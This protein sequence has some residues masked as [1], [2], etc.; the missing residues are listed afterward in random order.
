MHPLKLVMRL[1]RTLTVAVSAI[2][3][4]GATLPGRAVVPQAA[5][6]VMHRVVATPKPIPVFTP[7]RLEIPKIGVDNP[8]VPVYTTT[9]GR[10]GAPTTAADVGWWAGRKAGKGNVLLDGHHDWNGVEGSFYRLA[11]LKPGDRVIVK[12]DKPDQVLTYKIIWVKNFDRNINA[13]ELLNGKAGQVAT[14][15]TC[16]GTFDTIAHTH[17]ERV[18]ARATLV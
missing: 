16:G 2:A 14:L 3:V 1:R 7:T 10:M 13:K 12:G 5:P 18:V 15:I 6:V 9:D 11:D 4:A 8:V 17:R